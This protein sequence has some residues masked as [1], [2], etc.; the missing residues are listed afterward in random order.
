MK[1]RMIGGCMMAALA[2]A[3]ASAQPL[4]AAGA[5]ERLGAC[6]ASRTTGADR[7][8]VARWLLTALASA[9]QVAD[10]A[11]VSAAKREEANRAMAGLFTRLLTKDC[12]TEARVLFK[13]RDQS[14]FQVAGESLGRV[15]V[16]ELLNN[17]KALQ[18]MG[19]YSAYINEADFKDVVK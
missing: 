1:K 5:A 10:I 8:L 16:Q 13:A 2:M 4:P 15:A 11:S 19:A 18:A 17:P 9:P 7:I 12:A 14:G 3:P 6:L